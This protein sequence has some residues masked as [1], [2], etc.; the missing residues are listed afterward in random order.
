MQLKHTAQ[1]LTPCPQQPLSTLLVGRLC[2]TSLNRTARIRPGAHLYLF[3]HSSSH[4]LVSFSQD[5]LHH[6]INRIS[7]SQVDKSLLAGKVRGS[8]EGNLTDPVLLKDP[9]PLR[10]PIPLKDPLPPKV[11]ILEGFQGLG[12]LLRLPQVWDLLAGAFLG[13][14]LRARADLG[15]SIVWP[16]AEVVAAQQEDRGPMTTLKHT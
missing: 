15:R 11:V 1:S 6:T 4:L 10:D 3:P 5:I 7:I 12:H 2:H 13:N 8:M 14:A 16:G 9:L